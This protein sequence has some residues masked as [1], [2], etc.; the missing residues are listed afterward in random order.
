MEKSQRRCKRV[1]HFGNDKIGSVKG[2]REDGASGRKRRPPLIQMH[3]KCPGDQRKARKGQ[4]KTAITNTSR[5]K[6][7]E[8]QAASFD[9]LR[10]RWSDFNG[11]DLMVSSSRFGGL[12]LRPWAT[13]FFRGVQ[14]GGFAS[15][16]REF[17]ISVSC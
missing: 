4:S 7:V 1:Q 12:T 2:L 14:A 17:S 11:L 13:S 15:V 6:K 9:K 16:L 8:I 5:M 3:S 10:M